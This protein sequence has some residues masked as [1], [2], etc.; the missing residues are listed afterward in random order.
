MSFHSAA[1]ASRT[2]NRIAGVSALALTW[3]VAGAAIAAASEEDQAQP[4]VVG[5][6]VV[7]GQRLGTANAIS[8]QR[9][10]D[11]VVNVLSADDMGKLP[12]ANVADALARL[13]GVNV[14]V[15]QTTGE[16]E[17]VTVRGFA[18]TFNAYSINGVRVALTDTD[19]RKM[20]MTVLPPNGLQAIS[21]SKT[22]TPDMD[23][24]AIGGSI[25][26]RTPNAFDF[27]APVARLFASYGF[28]DRAKDQGESSDNYLLQADFG[29]RLKDER[30]GVFASINYG[31]SNGVTEETE[32]D[33]EWE[34]YI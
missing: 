30:F 6:V 9:R 34:P 29:R 28:N 26:F 22:L 15:N 21:V 3:A 7:T 17:Y 10:A 4:T 12:D 24:D 14:I 16:G 2:A 8:A 20:S 19:S 25:D 27:N 1:V 11:G 33:G 13:P 18:G 31:R 5:E 23:G 32:N